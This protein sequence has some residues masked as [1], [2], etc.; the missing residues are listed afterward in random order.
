MRAPIVSRKHYLQTSLSTVLAGAGLNIPIANGVAIQNVNQNFEVT[1]GSVVKAVYVEMWARS[2]DTG[3]GSVLM[4]LIKTTDGQTPVF[5]DVIALDA[6]DNKKNVLYHTQGN[7]NDQDS[8]ATPFIRQWFKIPK[9][10]QRIGL[11][12]TIQLFVAAQAL[13]QIICGFMT[14]KSYS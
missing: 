5:A 12:D 3:A 7:S 13:D 6:Y 11:G 1:E 8:T 2:G 10:K 9:G 4:S 14:Y